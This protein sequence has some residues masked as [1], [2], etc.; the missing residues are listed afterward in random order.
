MHLT[1]LGRKGVG[2]YSTQAMQGVQHCFALT[3]K[4]L[5]RRKIRVGPGPG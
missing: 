2:S 3:T 1:R 4:D 5:M